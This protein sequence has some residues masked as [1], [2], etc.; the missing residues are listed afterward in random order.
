VVESDESAKY[1]LFVKTFSQKCQDK[2]DRNAPA[3]YKK[4]WNQIA[5]TDETSCRD[6]NQKIN[7]SG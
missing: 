6:N 2:E 4:R 1:Y 7:E 3:N 5:I